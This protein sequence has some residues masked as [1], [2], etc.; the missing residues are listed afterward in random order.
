MGF[1]DAAKFRWLLRREA[2]RAEKFHHEFGRR[3]SGKQVREPLGDQLKQS[4]PIHD[5]E[6]HERLP[7]A[8]ALQFSLR[9]KLHQVGTQNA[10]V[11]LVRESRDDLP[12]LEGAFLRKDGE[13]F[14]FCIA[15][16]FG[17]RRPRLG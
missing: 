14:E 4:L 11:D 2:L 3:P 13:D 5:G 1:S 17:H 16:W 12:G 8:F 10:I 6:V 9:N 7:L 15:E